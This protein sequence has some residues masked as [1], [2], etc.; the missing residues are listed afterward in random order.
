MEKADLYSLLKQFNAI[1]GMAEIGQSGFCLLMALWQKANEL[2]WTNQ[3]T[4][5]NVELLYRSGYNSEKALN[6]KRQKLV[7]L[8]Y[9]KYVPPK[10]R[11]SCGTYIM[12]YNLVENRFLKYSIK[13]SSEESNQHSNESGS[14][15]GNKVNSGVGSEVHSEVHSEVG[16]DHHINKPNQTKQNKTKESVIITSPKQTFLEFVELTQEEH[17]KLN[18]RLGETQTKKYIERLNGYIGQIGVAKAKNKYVSHYHTILNWWRNDGQPTLSANGSKLS[19]V[20]EQPIEP[21]IK[22]SEAQLL[23]EQEL[24]ELRKAEERRAAG[25]VPEFIKQRQLA[26]QRNGGCADR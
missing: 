10:N 17:E 16:S 1:G 8:G 18:E 5:T 22:K 2:N 12:N 24:E 19:I 25:Y 11:R 9:F 21:F 23:F 26:R 3:F 15:E 7:S 13:E 6:E 20:P 4:M 14:K